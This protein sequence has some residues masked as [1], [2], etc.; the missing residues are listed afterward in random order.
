MSESQPSLL[1]QLEGLNEQQLRCLRVEHLTRQKLGLYWEASTIERDKALN[2]NLVFPRLVP[3]WS[4][5]A[6]ETTNPPPLGEGR[7]RAKAHNAST[8]SPQATGAEA[9]TP[10]P[11]PKG[12]GKTDLRN[13]IIEGDNFDS[14]RLLQATHRGRHS[15]W[16]EFLYRRLSLARDLLTPDGVILVPIN[17][18]CSWCAANTAIFSIRTS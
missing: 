13:L 4:H 8:T 15:Q 10:P 16:L 18:L 3:E 12:E 14:L 9:L 2:A 17:V 1:T 5:L 6:H 11:L 7:V